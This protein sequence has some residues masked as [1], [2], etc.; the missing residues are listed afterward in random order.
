M[1]R[2]EQRFRLI[3]SFA[4]I[5]LLILAV[6]C[7]GFFTNPVLQSITLSPAAPSVAVGSTQQM[8]AI[9]NFDDGSRDTLTSGV[10]WSASDATIATVSSTGLVTGVKAGNTTITATSGSIS[11][12]A[13]VTVTPSKLV[14]IAITP[15]TAAI[16]ASGQLGS[17]SSVTY[18]A[19]GT[20]QDG[21]TDDV[22]KSVTFSATPSGFV[23]FSSNVATAVSGLTITQQVTVTATSSN[24]NVVSNTASLT[25]SP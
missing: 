12:T 23:N 19:R 15:A 25:V 6:G 13:Q 1:P 22:S 18:T 8:T 3:A 9:G 11:G 7:H 5:V 17:S 2:T 20:F 10:T 24:G 21:S 14:S 16:S 4:G